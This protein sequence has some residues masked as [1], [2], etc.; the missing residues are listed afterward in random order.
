MSILEIWIDN[1]WVIKTLIVATLAVFLIALEKSYQFFKVYKALKSLS[2]I[3]KV[4]KYASLEESEVKDILEDVDGF[5]DEDKAL[6]NSN[7]GV[8]LDIFESSQMRYVGIIATIATLSPML[9]LIGTFIG[10]W[11]VFEGVGSVG[12]NDPAI[13][14]RGIKE[15]L[16]DTMAGLIVAV[17]AMVFYKTFEHLGQKNIMNF[18]DRLYKLLKN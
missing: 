13:I 17:I 12:L 7:V 10:V 16:I 15:V 18:E 1:D 5:K 6:F 11:H 8:K 14:A 2:T 9:G 4:N 3:E